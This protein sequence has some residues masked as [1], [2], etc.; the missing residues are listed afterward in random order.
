MKVD[1]GSVP[2]GV[3]LLLLVLAATVA[4]FWFG[5]DA[6]PA[7]ASHTEVIFAL[8]P[9]SN[10]AI[11]TIFL[12]LDGPPRTFYIRA[13]NI[14]DSTGMAAFGV[15]LL[16]DKTVLIPSTCNPDRPGSPGAGTDICII[17]DGTFLGSTGRV[18]NC[19]DQNDLA[20]PA[21]QQLPDPDNRWSANVN[22]AT[23]GQ[24]P[25]GPLGSGLLAEV[26]FQ[27]APGAVPSSFPLENQSS[28]LN[29]TGA[30]ET[31]PT[32]NHSPTFVIAN[33]GDVV[34]GDGFVVVQDIGAVVL[35][36]GSVPGDGHWNPDADLNKDGSVTISDIGL[37]VL[38]FGLQC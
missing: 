3:R 36:F 14:D 8:S 37:V 1:V 5:Q 16:F 11:S 7:R 38:Q 29:T 27:A 32:T 33:C 23:L 34:G 17:P 35:A 4:M 30:A 6:D 18:V 24:S 26:S 21:V 28:L 2:S 19:V 22:C 15:S 12:A 31:I 10:V 9:T 20:S 25:L 13:E